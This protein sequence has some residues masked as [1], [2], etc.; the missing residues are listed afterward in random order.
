[1]RFGFLYQKNLYDWSVKCLH[2]SKVPEVEEALSGCYFVIT[3]CSFL[4]KKERRAVREGRSRW[5][6]VYWF[7]GNLGIMEA[8][9]DGIMSLLTRT[10]AF[11]FSRRSRRLLWRSRLFQHSNIPAYIERPFSRFFNRDRFQRGI[12]LFWTPVHLDILV[13]IRTMYI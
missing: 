5:L 13:I 9:N 12:G 1:M 6:G 7:R 3:S 2:R 4:S 8:W 11:Q 10:P